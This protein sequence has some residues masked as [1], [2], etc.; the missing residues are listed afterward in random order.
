MNA[1]LLV[2]GEG[3]HGLSA[4]LQSARRGRVGHSCGEAIFSAGM[5][6]AR[7]PQGSAR[8]GGIRL[9]CHSA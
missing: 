2:I 8:S 1:D 9:N 5:L 4:A 7:L 6:Q 3:L